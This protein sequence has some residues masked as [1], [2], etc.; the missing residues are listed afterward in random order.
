MNLSEI[1]AKNSPPG[2]LVE[3][4]ASHLTGDAE[5]R[6]T[7]ISVLSE[8]ADPDHPLA[9]ETIARWEAVDRRKSPFIWKTVLHLAALGMLIAAVVSQRHEILFAAD[10]N[11]VSF[12]DLPE[13]M[14][15]KG[16]SP[17]EKL[18]LGDPSLEYYEDHKNGEALYF[19][20]PD[21]PAYFTDYAL[22]YN[23]DFNVLPPG[24]LE[25]AARIDPQNSF[26]LYLA[27]GQMDYDAIELGPRPGPRTKPRIVNGI[28]LQP[29]SVE[30]EYMIND[31]A[32]YEK[33]LELIEKASGLRG[34]R[35]YA[36]SMTRERMRCF[37]NT[38]TT[39]NRVFAMVIIYGQTSSAISLCKVS[40]T[41]S[42]RAQEL[43][44]NG[45]KEGFVELV[46][47][48]RH[49]IEGMLGNPDVSLI[50]ELVNLI[51][52]ANTAE[53]FYYAAKR[54]GLTDLEKEF[55]EQHKTMR[56]MADRRRLRSVYDHDWVTEKS[57]LIS[58]LT[59]PMIMHQ[60][61]SPPPIAPADIAPLRY[62]DH[63][64]AMRMGL[65]AVALSLLVFALPVYLFRFVFPASLRKTA[66]RL[67]QL[68][69][70]VDWILAVSLGVILPLVSILLLN[71]FTALGGREWALNHFLFLFPSVHLVATLLWVSLAPAAIIRWRLLSR[72]RALGLSGLPAI[73]AV[74]A[75]VGAAVLAIAAYPVVM[76][77]GLGTPILIGL[78]APVA[79]WLSVVF[80]N[81]LHG[82]I[83]RAQHRI[84]LAATSMAILPCL[85]FAIIAV[86]V[87]L[88][89]YKASEIHWLA[90]DTLYSI[91]PDAPD[92]GQYEFRI[93]AQKRKEI[94]EAL[95]MEN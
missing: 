21:N 83:G 89:V 10:L 24:F 19:S 63:A 90:Q 43:S 80:G 93:A 51:V 54:L 92:L 22:K 52:V 82:L 65:S 38:D 67:V 5:Q 31:Q 4:A 77:F 74:P 39:L 68:L 79:F 30:R 56:K 27:A 28:R 18:L 40:D 88:P 86:L 53:Y 42:A 23:S 11:N 59:F 46:T 95:S 7:A 71:R 72:A 33:S 85:S 81:A 9:A 66:A 20:E 2:S 58:G 47:M 41:L 60:V 13:P 49:F 62:A 14:L 8:S 37:R 69:R 44:N 50:N 12:F 35:S 36:K 32:V 94:R 64:L 87:V 29:P 57:S 25:T 26:Y 34:F 73:T 91:N 55:G 48:R 3:A 16:L 78:A 75:L 61:D 1:S 17:K 15:P 76:K 6:L 45:D 84:S 70:P